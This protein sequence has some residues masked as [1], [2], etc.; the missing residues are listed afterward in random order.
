MR[1]KLPFEHLER[2]DRD[3]RVTLRDVEIDAL[4]LLAHHVFVPRFIRRTG[5]VERHH[6]RVGS[7]TMLKST[8]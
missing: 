8:S 1:P 6:W 7:R 5:F 3:V 4:E 2:V